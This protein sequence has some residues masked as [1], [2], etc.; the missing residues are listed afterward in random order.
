M[1]KELKKNRDKELKESSKTMYKQNDN[2]N[3]DTEIIKETKYKFW[4]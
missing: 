4:N 2:M 3:Q 1:I